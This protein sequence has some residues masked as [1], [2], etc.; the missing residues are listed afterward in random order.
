MFDAAFGVR[1]DSSSQG[2]HLIMLVP[3]ETFDGVEMPYHLIDWKSSKLP[4]IARS[5]L[6]A[7]SQ[8]AGQSVD[9]VEFCCRFWEHLLKPSLDSSRRKFAAPRDDY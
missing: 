7:E 3:Q 9:A 4:R 8:A 1:R 2:G 5:S 6:G